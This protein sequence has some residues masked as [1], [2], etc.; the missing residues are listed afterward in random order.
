MESLTPERYRELWSRTYNTEG[1]PDWSHIFPY[2]HEDII[3][4]DCIQRIEGI[5]AFRAVCARVGID[6][7]EIEGWFETRLKPLPPSGAEPLPCGKP[8]EPDFSV[9]RYFQRRIARQ[10]AALPAKLETREA[11]AAYRF[12]GQ[13]LESLVELMRPQAA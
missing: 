9:V 3:F 13:R 1:K 7:A 8:E 5:E 2:Y 11:W 12:P 10:A 4:E 6:L